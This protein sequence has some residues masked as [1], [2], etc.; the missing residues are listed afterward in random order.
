[1]EIGSSSNEVVT[2]TSSIEH[3]LF[4]K[5][6]QSQVTGIIH[7]WS[8]HLEAKASCSLRFQ[9]WR[10]VEGEKYMLVNQTEAFN[11]PT[12]V[13]TV[14]DAM[15]IATGD[16]IGVWAWSCQLPRFE[17]TPAIYNASDVRYRYI[18][19]TVGDEVHFRTPEHNDHFFLSALLDM[20][21][22]GMYRNKYSRSFFLFPHY[23]S[24]LIKSL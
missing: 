18:N 1:M 11:A 7:R 19:S 22:C 16:Y 21:H 6:W 15:P 9:I 17:I 2:R 8:I 4:C 24:P 13:L 5:D 14:D 10:Q 20:T 3:S 23:L 12:E